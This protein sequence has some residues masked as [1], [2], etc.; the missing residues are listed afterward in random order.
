MRQL[1]LAA[2]MASTQSLAQTAPMPSTETPTSALLLQVGTDIRLRL[3]DE[4][5]T[6][7]T[8]RGTPFQLEV[9]EDILVDGQVAIPEGTMAV[10]EVTRSEPKGAFGKSGKLEA[11]V[12]Y[13]VVD[14]RPV[15]MSG[16]LSAEGEGGTT[17]TVLTALAAGTLAFV[18]T[19]KSA[20]LPTGRILV[21]SLDR[22][23]VLSS[24]R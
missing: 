20:A 13:L 2:A 10:G 24:K 15:R 4:L 7:R 6:R 8:P 23:L 1:L 3:L 19:G 21:A 17:E 11:R 14:G 9:A 18:I 22:E 5:S 16:Q 12:L